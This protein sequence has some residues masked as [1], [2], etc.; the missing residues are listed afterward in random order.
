MDQ[1]KRLG[2]DAIVAEYNRTHH[3]DERK[4]VLTDE[5]ESGSS[6]SSCEEISDINPRERLSSDTTSA[7]SPPETS[8]TNQPELRP[9]KPD[10]D[11]SATETADEGQT[12]EEQKQNYSQQATITVVN[13]PTPTMLQV[14]V[15]GTENTSP[16]TVKDLMLN[17][18]E[19]QLMKNQPGISTSHPPPTSVSIS[20]VSNFFM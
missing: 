1:R 17:V 7:N 20:S 16:M 19:K 4:P 13:G 10:Y 3:G 15:R 14:G 9:T 2:L 12:V 5:E 18:I 6:T 11:S 8:E